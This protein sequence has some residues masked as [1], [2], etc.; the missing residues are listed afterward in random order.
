MPRGYWTSRTAPAATTPPPE[1]GC[2]ALRSIVAESTI[3]TIR[4]GQDVSLGAVG[5]DPTPIIVKATGLLRGP[6]ALTAGTPR[7]PAMSN[8]GNQSF[9]VHS[10]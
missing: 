8:D 9:K 3:S 1:D 6:K 4:F 2:A 7:A 5:A 10:G